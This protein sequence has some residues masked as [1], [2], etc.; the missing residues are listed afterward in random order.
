ME[1]FEQLPRP[2]T[3][4]IMILYMEAKRLLDQGLADNVKQAYRMVGISQTSFYRCRRWLE[5]G[6]VEVIHNKY[7]KKPRRVY[8]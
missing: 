7:N 3:K 6:K 4:R 5:E 2:L 1:E 8:T